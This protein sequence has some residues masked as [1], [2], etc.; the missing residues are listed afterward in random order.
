MQGKFGELLNALVLAGCVVVTVSYLL[1]QLT[2]VRRCLMG[3][4]G[5]LH[6]LLVALLL[7]AITTAGDFIT[8]PYARIVAYAQHLAPVISGL[9]GGPL[10]GA[11]AGVLAGFGQALLRGA[12]DGTQAL[13]AVLLGAMSGWLGQRPGPR[14]SWRRAALVATAAVTAESLVTW[15][16]TGRVHDR[17]LALVYI[18]SYLSNLAAIVAVTQ[19]FDR[20]RAEEEHKRV[21]E[22]LALTD[23][24]THLANHRQFHTQLAKEIEQARDRGS[25]VALIMLDIDYFKQYNDTFGHPEGDHLLAAIGESIRSAIRSGDTGAR[26]GGDEFAIIL[27]GAGINE[28]SAVSRRVQ[29]AIAHL[30]RQETTGRGR[31]MVSLSAGVAVYPTTASE[32][33]ELIKRADEALYSAKHQESKLEI[34]HS[35]FDDLKAQLDSSELSLVNTVKTLLT[36]INAKDRYTYGHSER[37]VT[38]C[39]AVARHLELGEE[40]TKLLRIAAFLHD[41]GKIEIARDILCKQER[42]TAEEREV[43]QQHPV[44][45]AEIIQPVRSLRQVVPIVLHHHERWDGSGYPNHLKG[46]EVTRAARILAVADAFDAMTTDRPYHK[47]MSHTE[48]LAELKRCAGTQFDPWVVDAF[49]AAQLEPPSVARAVS[50]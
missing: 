43:I 37:V 35:V 49:A 32:K 50:G 40:E 27:P 9:Y 20:E 11:L 1:S 15:V 42:L 16:L 23:G 13:T 14:L 34:Y 3:E 21:L 38:Y 36:V 45:G 12:W 22:D 48:A 18:P 4:A 10:V 41:I 25:R 28:A 26:Y 29:E 33:D 7:E 19:I 17:L 47:A 31:P 30:A 39:L 6:R 24:L 5:L 46:N 2:L 8:Y 44:W